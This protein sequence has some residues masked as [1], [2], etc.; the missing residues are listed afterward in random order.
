MILKSSTKKYQMIF[1]GHLYAGEIQKESER[2][3][4]QRRH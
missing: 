2:S 4:L 1:G 3:V